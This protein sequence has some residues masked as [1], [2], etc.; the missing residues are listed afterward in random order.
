[1]FLVWTPGWAVNVRN[2]QYRA[3]RTDGTGLESTPGN[4]GWFGREGQSPGS[5]GINVRLTPAVELV[6]RGDPTG[7]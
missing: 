7:L 3:T 1:M 4:E 2:S 5:S 6:V